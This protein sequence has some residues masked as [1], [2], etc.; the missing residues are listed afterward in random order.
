MSTKH[1]TE[2]LSPCQALGLRWYNQQCRDSRFIFEDFYHKGGPAC[3][4]YSQSFDTCLSSSL[5]DIST[6]PKLMKGQKVVPILCSSRRTPELGLSWSKSHTRHILILVALFLPHAR[7]GGISF[8]IDY[9][10]FKGLFLMCW[11]SWCKG[12]RDTESPL[13]SQA[14]SKV[15]ERLD[16]LSM[17]LPSWILV[18]K[19]S[20]FH[21]TLVD[22]YTF[23]PV[24]CTLFCSWKWVAVSELLNVKNTMEW[25]TPQRLLSWQLEKSRTS[26][27]LTGCR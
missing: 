25:T 23:C 20:L 6:G 16:E 26:M 19:F 17:S 5:L 11:Y 2:D 21:N 24:F 12:R 13:S 15:S 8:W 4:Q 18:F 1:F 27:V 7:F 14:E 9:P 10:D 3:A 22:V